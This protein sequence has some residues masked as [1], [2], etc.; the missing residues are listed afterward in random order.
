MT[1]DRLH[2]RGLSHAVNATG[3]WRRH[4]QHWAQPFRRNL[5]ATILAV[6]LRA[7][8]LRSHAEIIKLFTP[9]RR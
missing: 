1:L 7:G 8:V 4:R 5:A 3:A 9:A 2:S 6:F